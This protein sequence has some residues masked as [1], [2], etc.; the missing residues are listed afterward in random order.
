MTLT[1]L[2]FGTFA[3]LLGLIAM[4]ATGAIWLVPRRQLRAVADVP[5]RLDLENEA[6]KTLAQIG[7]S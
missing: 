2:S 1:T 4:A 5:K 6:R 7:R 3:L